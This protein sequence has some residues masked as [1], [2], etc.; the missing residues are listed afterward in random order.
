MKDRKLLF[1]DIDGTLLSEK[2]HT[3]PQSAKDALKKAKEKGH[4]I[5]INTGRPI[6]TI[7]QEIHDLNPDGYICGCGTYI[8]YHNKTIYHYQLSK[9]RCLEIADLIKKYEIDAVLESKD[10]VYFNENIKNSFVK[11]IKERYTNNGFNVSSSEDSHL[12][13]DKFT[14]FFD[15]DISEFR[16]N[17]SQDF[18]IIERSEDMIEVVPKGH[19]KATGIQVVAD[20]FESN[21]DH[22]YVFGD[23]FN[24][25]SMLLYVKHSIVMANGVQAMKNIAYFVTKDIED[26]GIAYALE[27]LGII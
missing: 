27:K 9:E 6:S 5:F 11:E 17:I 22:C 8:T 3:V 15:H 16:K 1:F 14:A 7:D 19:S 18:D 21:L 13:F 24:D 4:L 25:E 20:D 26:D 12:S 10:H 23:S 2:T